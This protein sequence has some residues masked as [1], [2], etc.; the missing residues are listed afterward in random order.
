[1]HALSADAG[2]DGAALDAADQAL[3][4]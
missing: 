4:R 3:R 2:E 1:V